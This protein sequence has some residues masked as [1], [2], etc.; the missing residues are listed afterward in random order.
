MLITELKITGKLDSYLAD[1]NE[2]AED[3]RNCR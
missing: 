3:K 1:L 2:W